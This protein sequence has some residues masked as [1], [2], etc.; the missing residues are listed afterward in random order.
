MCRNVKIRSFLAPVSWFGS[1]RGCHPIYC[2]V[3]A[4]STN[5]HHKYHKSIYISASSQMVML[6]V[7]MM[8]ACAWCKAHTQVEVFQPH[9]PFFRSQLVINQ[10]HS[11]THKQREAKR[12]SFALPSGLEVNRHGE[13]DKSCKEKL[14]TSLSKTLLY[15]LKCLG[16]CADSNGTVCSF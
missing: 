12:N 6:M 2:E 9:L 13:S 8:C 15:S 5:S 11:V 4:C 14:T 7:M 3:W 10:T 16:L 1:Q